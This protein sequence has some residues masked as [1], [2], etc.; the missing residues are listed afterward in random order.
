[1]KLKK[2]QNTGLVVDEKSYKKYYPELSKTVSY[3]QF[4]GELVL[5]SSTHCIGSQKII[6]T[7]DLPW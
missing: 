1:M 7:N 5:E 4:T 2:K 6:D 3:G